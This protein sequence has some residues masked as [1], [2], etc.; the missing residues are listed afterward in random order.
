MMSVKRFVMSSGE[1]FAILL[2]KNGHP[3]PYPNLYSVIYLRN[4]GQSINTIVAVLEDL[5]LLYQLLD[6]L[7]IDLEQRV[8]NKKFLTLNEV[9]AVVN[10][11]S[12]QRK[13][14]LNQKT[15]KRIL[16]FPDKV[17]NEKIRAKFILTDDHVS[18]ELVYRRI[19]NFAEYIGWLENYFSPHVQTRTKTT[20]KAHRPKKNG[21]VSNLYKSFDKKQL[22]QILA[23][24]HPEQ[25]S[26]LWASKFHN[27]RNEL[28]VFLLLYLGCRKG[29][30]LNIKLTDREE[31]NGNLYINIVRN[32]DDQTDIRLHQPLVKTRSRAIVINQKLREKLESYVLYY[33]SEIPNA[34]L[35]DFLI[36][37]DNGQP[38]SINGLNKVFSKISEKLRFNVHAHAFRHTWNDKYTDNVAKL[39]ANGKMTESEA[40]NHRAYLQGWIIG[41]QS[42]RRYSKR[43]E[44]LKAVRVG[45]DIQDSFE[46]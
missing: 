42:A 34:E 6:K 14:L 20:F 29:E 26:P 13:Y 30:L 2:D 45:L 19:T 22:D 16:S 3:L 9:E 10:L 39:I 24:V 17:R 43:S 32:R 28:I 33:R 4:I 8:Q 18:K 15:Q 31:K 1:R 11:T 21:D 37:S 38:L 27:Y 23:L 46:E 35:T 7:E 12:F 40:E 36:I 5:K 41:S 44:N 25:E